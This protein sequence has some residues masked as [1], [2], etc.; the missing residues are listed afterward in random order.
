MHTGDDSDVAWIGHLGKL[1]EIRSRIARV[2]VDA[3]VIGTQGVHYDEDHVTS[4]CRAGRDVGCSC[5]VIYTVEA[6]RD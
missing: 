2:A 1:V 6:L 5:R 3:H 4:G